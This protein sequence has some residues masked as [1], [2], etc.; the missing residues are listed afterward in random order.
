MMTYD[1]M[2]FLVTSHESP[3]TNFAIEVLTM[4][5]EDLDKQLKEHGEAMGKEISGSKKGRMKLMALALALLVA[6][7][8]G[9]CFFGSGLPS[10]NK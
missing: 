2:Y 6:G 9:G 7:G 1:E 5:R 8:A 4:D 3:V 10:I